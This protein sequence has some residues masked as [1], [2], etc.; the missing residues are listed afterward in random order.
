[1]HLYNFSFVFFNKM[2]NNW[3]QIQATVFQFELNV[4]TCCT[5][6]RFLGFIIIFCMSDVGRMLENQ[7]TLFYLILYCLHM[8]YSCIYWIYFLYLDLFPV[9]T[10]SISCIKISKKTSKTSKRPTHATILSLGHR[11]HA[12]TIFFITNGTTLF[13]SLKKI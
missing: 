11:Y 2:I 6:F 8:Q 5:T 7:W 10:G 1:M 13:S 3:S 4:T 12:R 9:S